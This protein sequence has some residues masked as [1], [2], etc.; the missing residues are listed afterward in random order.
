M[1]CGVSGCGDLVLGAVAAALDED[2]F[3]VMEEAVQEC[4]GEGGV[5][6]EDLR[7]VFVGAVGGEDCG[8][9]LV[10]TGQ[11][12]EQEVGAGLVDGPTVSGV[13]L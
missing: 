9:L 7:P 1:G 10:A 13:Q 8:H 3:D 6:V 5:V 12:L 2:G 11:D 4:G